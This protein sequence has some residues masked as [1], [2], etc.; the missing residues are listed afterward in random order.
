MPGCV[1]PHLRSEVD[2]ELQHRQPHFF[3]IDVFPPD[4]SLAQFMSFESAQEVKAR[5]CATI[6]RM[7]HHSSCQPAFSGIVRRT[8]S[9]DRHSARSSR[10]LETRRPAQSGRRAARHPYGVKHLVGCRSPASSVST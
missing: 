9:G 5:K 1:L 8:A 3:L 4:E 6:E 10:S 7:L 2:N